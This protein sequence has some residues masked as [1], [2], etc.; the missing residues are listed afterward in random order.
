MAKASGSDSGRGD[1]LDKPTSRRNT[2]PLHA[3]NDA[4]AA[5]IAA[6]APLVFLARLAGG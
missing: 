1:T 3:D 5:V 4:A 6:S 2:S